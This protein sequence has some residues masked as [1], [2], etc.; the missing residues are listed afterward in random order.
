M[1]TFCFTIDDNIRFLEQL[2]SGDYASMFE[3]PYLSLMRRLH[4]KYDLRVQLN[5]FYQNDTFDL[6]YMTDKYI[7]EWR[8]NS[9]WLKMSFHSRRENVNPYENSGYEEV[10]GDCLQ[11]HSEIQRFAGA[12]TLADTTTI[13]YCLATDEGIR[14]LED[15]G[16]RGLLGLYL[17]KGNMRS[18]YQ[19][20]PTQCDSI[21]RGEIVRQGGISYAGIDIVLNMYTTDEILSMLPSFEDR[22]HISVMIHEQY[23]YP[24]YKAY[25]PDFADKLDATFEYL[26]TRGYES[27]FFEEVL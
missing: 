25:Q 5:L 18:S 22:E 10:Y 21:R 20:T 3:H 7:E 11:V 9:H 19:N 15:N 13:H 2:T 1:K 16:V 26:T 4:D 24:D 14:A 23:F 12:D 6:S 17:V 27:K 8:E